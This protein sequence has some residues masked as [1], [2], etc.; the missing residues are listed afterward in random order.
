MTAT[1][2]PTVALGRTGFAITR[3]GFG[4]W[5]AGGDWMFGWG[6]QDDAQSIAAIRR[7]VDLGINWIDTAPIY[8]LGH[9]EE[10]IG[11]ALADIPR[12]ER[13]YVFTKCG[14]DW[15]TGERAMPKFI[16]RRDALQKEL[17]ASLRRLRVEAID[18]WQVHWPAHDVGIEDYWQ[19]LVDARAAGKVRAIGLSN[20]AVEA[21]ERAEAI[22]HVDTLQPPF[23][24]IARGAAADVIPW[25]K[26]H[27]TGVIVYSPMQSGLLT[28]SFSAERAA[29]LSDLDWRK[30][31]EEF[32]GEKLKR[33][34]SLAAALAPIAERHGVTVGTVAIAWTLAFPGV[35]AAI[36]GARSPTQ[37]EGWSAAA[38]FALSADEDD[39]I[40]RA[41]EATGAGSGP[42]AA[43]DAR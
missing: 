20:H 21:L 38:R 40:G 14:L 43:T 29:A 39:E 34:L 17:D 16:G 2:L 35:T 5:A 7:A 25:A 23:S 1:A 32:N 4:A 12:S 19:T 37:V 41:I 15:G 31:D 10:L 28:G 9:S 33:N 36:V 18:L 24:A 27:E 26:A 11:A 6:H 42:L 22:G 3:V 13:P 30:A 8:G